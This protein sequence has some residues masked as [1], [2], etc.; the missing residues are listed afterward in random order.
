MGGGCV[1]IPDM[2]EKG[3]RGNLTLTFV[4]VAAVN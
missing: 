2:G 1:E 3:D 4:S